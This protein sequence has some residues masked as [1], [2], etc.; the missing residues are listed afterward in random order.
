MMDGPPQ[1]QG[2]GKE[3]FPPLYVKGWQDGCETG[4]SSNTNSINKFFYAY[5]Q[6]AN[7]VLNHE[8]IFFNMAGSANA[9]KRLQ[10]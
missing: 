7:L 9:G 8:K 5:K 4:I 2:V 1:R 3:E 6:D 10:L